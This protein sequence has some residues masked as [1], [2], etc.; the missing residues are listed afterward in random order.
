MSA[1]KIDGKQIAERV[2]EDT[3]ARVAELNKKGITPGLAVVLVGENPA[4]H[5]YVRNK[6]RACEKVGI[7]TFDHKLPD[8]TTEAD[9]LK[10]IQQL[11]QDDVVHGILVQLPLPKHIDERSILQAIIPSKDVDGFHPVN[12]G[13]LAIGQDS[14]FV[15]CTPQ[16]SMILINEIKQDLTGLHAV[17][18]GRSNI[19]GK[20]MAQLLLQANC[21]ITVAHS[22]TKNTPELC[23]NAD[24]IVAAVGVPHLVK[25]DWIKPG[26]IVI[27]VGINRLE[28]GSLAGDV[29]YDEVA[30]VAG[31]VTP[32]PGG[33]GPMTIAC[34]LKNTVL[35]AE[36]TVA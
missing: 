23:R 1:V 20:P 35:S 29:A 14:G 32:V 18:V 31:A 17:V 28:D 7:Q 11:N 25:K 24:I 21:T 3:A 19:V 16:G 8:T 15:P 10:L 33:V 9:L 26:A 2:N 6:H 5:V 12:A 27:D 34:L 22:T 36:R 13:Q 4:S 30:E